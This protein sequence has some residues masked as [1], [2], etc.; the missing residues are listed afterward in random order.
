MIVLV[1]QH[2]RSIIISAITSN[3]AGQ[4]NINNPGGKKNKKSSIP[5]PKERGRDTR[6][7]RE[8]ER[9]SPLS[10]IN[11]PLEKLVKFC[12]R[13]L[14]V[15]PSCLSTTLSC[16]PFFHRNRRSSQF[17]SPKTTNVII[18]IDRVMTRLVASLFYRGIKNPPWLINSQPPLDLFSRNMAPEMAV[19]DCCGREL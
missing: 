19:W 13:H 6:R 4:N 18:V 8:R 11:P 10:F 16:T 2:S 12:I 9:G 15:H 3:F 5:F 7:E 14:L 1:L 17:L